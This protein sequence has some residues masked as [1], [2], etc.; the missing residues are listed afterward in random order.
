MGKWGPCLKIGDK[1][2]DDVVRLEMNEILK[3][4]GLTIRDG[5]KI[6]VDLGL[7]LGLA[8]LNISSEG[9]ANINLVA[10][11]KLP[12]IFVKDGDGK[13]LWSTLKHGKEGKE[14]SS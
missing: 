7:C 4:V 12:V 9:E 3:T 5:E 10:V 8:S 13:I 11:D 6:R 1:N 14:P 2:G